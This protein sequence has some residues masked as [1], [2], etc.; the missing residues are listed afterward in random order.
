MDGVTGCVQWEQCQQTTRHQH[1]W[2]MLC[3]L[4]L[5]LALAC[6]LDGLQALRRSEAN[7]LELLPGESAAISGPI[8]VRN[9]TSRDIQT[10]F[11]PEEAPLSFSFDGFFTGYIFGSGMWRG[12]VLAD[13]D[14]LPGR[15]ILHVRFRGTPGSV[16]QRYPVRLYADADDMRAASFSCI[17]RFVG[18]NPFV[19]AAGF[20]AVGLS[21]GLLVFLL[22]QRHIRQ[23]RALGCGEVVMVRQEGGNVCLWCLLYG[24]RALAPGAQ[25]AVLNSRGEVAGRA[26]ITAV[27]KGTLEMQ[28][29][30]TAHD[31]AKGCLVLLRPQQ[32]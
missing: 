7:L 6:V 12:K 5:A 2:G 23:L 27:R 16:V 3:A 22:G 21:T 8:A 28:M 13:V 14:A 20:C 24:Q 26:Y 32:N 9:P 30:D 10:H 18:Q 29:A 17:R 31:V 19:L 11:S 25:C 4:F 15:Y 1:W